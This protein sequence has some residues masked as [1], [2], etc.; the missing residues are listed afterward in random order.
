MR[1]SPRSSLEH[2]T[3]LRS[4][5]Q[6]IRCKSSTSLQESEFERVSHKRDTAG[7]PV[8][9]GGGPGG[10]VVRGPRGKSRRVI[11]SLTS[12]RHSLRP[13][14]GRRKETRKRLHE[15]G[16]PT[17]SRGRVHC[18]S[19]FWRVVGPRSYLLIKDLA[20]GLTVLHVV[21][22][23]SGKSGQTVCAGEANA[24][25]MC[26]LPWVSSIRKLNLDGVGFGLVLHHK[27]G[28]DRLPTVL[29]CSG[30]SVT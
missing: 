27:A 10:Q 30:L 26:S 16:R 4:S 3:G 22:K 24:K 21:G 29:R 20:P 15:G 17:D 12:T 23:T 28:Q 2:M 25:C 6:H 9:E 14:H 1:R 5:R 19:E 11:S 18:T 8:F 13:R 7:V